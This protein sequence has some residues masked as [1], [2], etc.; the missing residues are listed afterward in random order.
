VNRE[1][2]FAD[3]FKTPLPIS[4]PKRISLPQLPAFIATVG[5]SSM[6]I[7]ADLE[8]NTFGISLGK[9]IGEKGNLTVSSIEDIRAKFGIPGRS[10]V[11]LIGTGQDRPLENL[12]K[13]H[14]THQIFERLAQIRFD[15]VTS[16]TFSVWNTEFP[17][18]D[19]L[20]NY[21]RNLWT[22]D[23]FV[24]L[25]VPCIPFFFPVDEGDFA[26]LKIWLSQRPEVN[27]VAVY[28][29]F[30]HRE[31]AF[32]SYINYLVKIQECAGRKLRFLVCGI[33]KPE[34]IERLG[35]KF[36]CL[37]ENSSMYAK[38]IHGLVCDSQLK[39]GHSPFALD[40]VFRINLQRNLSFCE[41]VNKPIVY[42][43]RRY[44][45]MM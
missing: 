43:K 25:G 1:R 19:Q 38:S 16:L 37:F 12:W 40:D 39:Y 32:S 30:F 24:S 4:N 41:S 31:E 11:I 13:I 10:K 6:T 3:T 21:H 26:Y 34:N 27:T 9:I 5:E 33:G 22:Y 14:R 20:R 42:L 15:C 44:V 17:R 8:A 2:L 29:R 7:P 35:R 45:Q 36:N 18:P 23:R 28:A